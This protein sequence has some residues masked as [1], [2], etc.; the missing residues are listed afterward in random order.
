[1]MSA[2]KIIKLEKRKQ[3]FLEA[4]EITERSKK[5]IIEFSQNL[6]SLYSSRKITGEEYGEKLKEA[7]KGKTAEQWLVYYNSYLNHYKN[8]IDA[9]EKQISSFR[10]KKV[11]LILVILI[12]LVL[13]A[14]LISLLSALQPNLLEGIGEKISSVFQP[15]KISEVSISLHDKEAV[16]SEY[17]LIQHQAVLG[18]P[19]KWEKSFIINKSTD[20]S[21]KLPADSENIK[22]KKIENS[23][24][25]NISSLSIEKKLF[26]GEIEVKVEKD[27]GGYK[28]EYETPAPETS[29]LEAEGRVIKKILIK[30]P[31]N[32][33]YTNILSFTELPKEFNKNEIG[34][35]KLY[36]VKNNQ[37]IK[38]EFIAYD[39]DENGLLDYIEWL[40]P[41]LSEAVFE[42]VIE[43]S[44]AEH[45]DSERSFISDI[46]EQVYRLD[47]I[48][49]EKINDR[50]YVRVT[51]FRKLD[52][53]R[54]ITIYIRIV[55][56]NPSIEVYEIDGSEKIAEFT[57]LNSDEYNQVYLTDLVG[58]QDTFD[59]RIINGEVK[60]EHIV[61]PFITKIYYFAG[62][63]SGTDELSTEQGTGTASWST[64]TN[65][66]WHYWTS[67]SY[68]QNTVLT[69]QNLLVSFW[70]N[71]TGSIKGDKIQI[72]SINY[73]DCSDSSCTARTEICSTNSLN[74]NCE[75]NG[76]AVNINF[77]A[78]II[79][80]NYTLVAGHYL[81]VG[82]MARINKQVRLNVYFNSSQYPSYF[83]M[84][85]WT[86]D[87]TPP[88]VNIISPLNQ[89]YF[90]SSIDFNFT[91]NEAGYCEYSLDSGATNYTMT[92]NSSNTGFNATNTNIAD[93]SYTINAYC[94]DTAGNKNYTS[95]TT[96]NVSAAVYQPLRIIYVSEIPPITPVEAFST[97]V[98]FY[99]TVYD[100]KGADN[101]NDTS[102]KV[103]FIR[104]ESARENECIW[105][106]DIDSNSADYSCSVDMWYW[107][108]AG[109]WKISVYAEDLNGNPALNETT[110]FQYDLLKAIVISPSELTWPEIIP[111]AVN[112]TPSFPTTI[113]N[114]G[115]YNTTEKIAVQA[116]NLY[117]ETDNSEFIDAGNF[118]VG[119]DPGENICGGFS[120]VNGTNITIT[121]SVLEAGN[122]S[123]GEAKERVY[124]CLKEV[125]LI[126]SQT[127]STRQAGSWIITVLIASIIIKKKKQNSKKLK[128]NLKKDNLSISLNL[129]SKELKQDYSE[130][131]EKIAKLLIKEIKKKYRINN[132][133]IAELIETRKEITIPLIIFKEKL[134]ALEVLTRY[135][136]ENL[137]MNYKEIAIL[138]NRDER[139]IW[140]AYHKSK[141]KQK[142]L[143][144]IKGKNIFLPV[145]AFNEKLTILESVI[146]YLKKQGRSYSEIA[147]LL[148]RDQRNIWAI[149]SRAMRKIKS[150]V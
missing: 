48:W 1:M 27:E 147:K 62:D 14:V 139:T 55:S 103:N 79:S 36:E 101:L 76:P 15:S 42:L 52:N 108:E 85:E 122:L 8:Q 10:G 87:T 129:V 57:S 56:G 84:T 37:R 20:F 33:H 125:P 126:S 89:T 112:Q 94:N 54:D 93:G 66:D 5:Q 141:K 102:V 7:L 40:T 21:L 109:T 18:K 72:D 67:N 148:G 135:L 63:G 113:I 131:K 127:Y 114:T 105:L 107:D 71:N 142:E 90:Q 51:F 134:G 104:G 70:C 138:L 144:I 19:V 58:E 75:V 123:A 69:P 16:L 17:P 46:Y 34:K 133:E 38:T 96:F 44:K 150:K 95:T 149:Y 26:T 83:S 9:C 60:L 6:A 99:A 74:L 2:E 32:V 140:T 110:T 80:S 143:I 132:K 3:K 12:I 115:N 117:G 118:S 82:F 81:A 73:F 41:E 145:S 86:P 24:E 47:N 130:E 29:E 111:G 59:L 119:I 124:Y 65:G 61:D 50:E 128:N 45:L 11:I 53:T 88:D 4:V 31:D 30:G 91:L 35:L 28:I 98:N 78:C 100:A 106:K 68:S 22:L 13:M 137:A 77:S 121:N 97:T 116:A 23:E 136:K 64:E 146:V 43:I 120:L 92:A 25:R 49:S 39:T